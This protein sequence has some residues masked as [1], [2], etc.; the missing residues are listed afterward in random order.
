MS[1]EQSCTV[2]GS[3]SVAVYDLIATSSTA[4]DEAQKNISSKEK[5]WICARGATIY[6]S[7]LGNA[8]NLKQGRLSGVF[9]E[10]AEL[11]GARVT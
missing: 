3:I 11:A 2:N 4:Y 1:V 8:T 9:G 10:V 5:T 7:V 6:I